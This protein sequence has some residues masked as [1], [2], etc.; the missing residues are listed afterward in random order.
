MPVKRSGYSGIRDEIAELLAACKRANPDY[1]ILDVGGAAMPFLPEGMA[2]VLDIQPGATFVGDI[3]LPETWDRFPSLSYD[4]VICSH[5]LED[6]RDP[7]GVLRQL[8]RISPHGF[9]EMPHK[10]HELSV[11]DQPPYVGYCHH[12]WIFTV[13]HNK[14]RMIAKWPVTAQLATGGVKLDW[15]RAGQDRPG[16]LQVYWEYGLDFEMINNDFAGQPEKGC[17]GILEMYEREL[18]EGI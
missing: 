7:F 9:L 2:D 4:F 10:Y 5:T 18:A 14:L 11:I 6:V 12:R 15:L 16:D 1:K 17:A 3:C 8:T 13:Q